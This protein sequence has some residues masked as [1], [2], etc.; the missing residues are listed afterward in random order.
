MNGLELT[1]LYRNTPF[2]TSQTRGQ[3]KIPSAGTNAPKHVNAFRFKQDRCQGK[4]HLA[5]TRN[6]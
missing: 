1:E 2:W 6:V 5:G 4:L 3:T